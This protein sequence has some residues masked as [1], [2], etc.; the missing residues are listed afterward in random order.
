MPLTCLS[1]SKAID[2]GQKD[3][4]MP[5]I[6]P[7]DNDTRKEWQESVQ[8]ESTNQQNFEDRDGVLWLLLE[9]DY[10]EKDK[11]LKD[12]LIPTTL[13]HAYTLV[14]NWLKEETIEGVYAMEKITLEENL[15]QYSN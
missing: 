9:I 1:T 2:T 15:E 8:N 13:F 12:K 4:L 5:N 11:E 3:Q 10:Y 6:N 14:T 7:N